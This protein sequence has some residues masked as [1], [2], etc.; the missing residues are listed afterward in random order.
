VQSPQ[1]VTAGEVLL[2]SPKTALA[3]KIVVVGGGIIGCECAHYLA[4]E[5]GKQVSLVEM[6]PEIMK[7][8]CTANRGHLIRM[9]EKA[10]VKLL[11]CTRLVEIQPGKVVVERNVSKTVPEPYNTWSPL[12]PENINNPLAS[13]QRTEIQ[14]QTIDADLGVLASGLQ[15][16]QELYNACLQLGGAPRLYQ[17]GDAFEIKGVFEAVKAGFAVGRVI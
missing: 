6:L 7:G 5:L 11:N 12:L 2:G 13:R 15:P 14:V 3:Q 16:D 8:V 1:V 4:V 10:G 9:L 17:I